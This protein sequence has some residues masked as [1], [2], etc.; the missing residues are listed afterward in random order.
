[1]SHL[2]ETLVLLKP[3]AIER[4]LCGEILR[5]LEA[6]G[7]RIAGIRW[8]RFTV[9][10]VGRH[11]AELRTKQPEVFAR[12]RRFLPGKAVVAVR[13][14]GLNA[15]AKVRALAGPTDC[16]AAPASTIRGDLSADS[17]ASAGDEDRIVQNL[18][19]A[20]DSPA[21]ARRELRLWFP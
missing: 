19:H 14:A 11:Y 16:L 20:A 4:G 9:P 17:V 6:A 5:R 1:M 15:I 2:Q 3:D 7:L 10:L 18:I 13:V 21:S 12:A 8:V